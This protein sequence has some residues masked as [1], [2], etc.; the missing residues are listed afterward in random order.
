MVYGGEMSGQW[1]MMNK[2]VR[3][4]VLP[5]LDPWRRVQPV[6]VAD[7]TDGLIKI[8]AL[9]RP[10]RI[11]FG[12]GDPLPLPFGRYLG[13]LAR[14]GHNRRILIL[15]VPSRIAL[16][17]VD[18]LYR[19]PGLPKIDRE[20]I[21]GLAGLP[22]IET[23]G[24]LVALDIELRP[25]GRGLAQGNPRG[26]TRYRKA[27]LREGYV[28]LSYVAAA[29]PRSGLLRAY[30]RAVERMGAGHGAPV[31]YGRL[32]VRFPGLMRIVEPPVGAGP[33]RQRLKLA[34]RLSE[35]SGALTP[36]PFD[37]QGAGKGRAWAGLFKAVMIE[38]L[39]LA[40]RCWLCP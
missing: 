12:L 13:H 17:L 19:L 18:I 1:G 25:L 35:M 31:R 8:A 7:L 5:M 39:C 28:H 21:L 6:H 40:P 16:L 36:G 32:M 11:V 4:L 23:A 3:L 34:Y 33:V 22:V 29:P 27:L 26:T 38:A 14:L 20:R 9:S 30:V 10:R 24:D 37:Y 15:P 2:L